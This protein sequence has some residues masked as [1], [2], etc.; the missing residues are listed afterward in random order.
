MGGANS[1]VNVFDV[2]SY[3]KI[4]DAKRKTDQSFDSSMETIEKG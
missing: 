3:N 2:N 4:A 1:I